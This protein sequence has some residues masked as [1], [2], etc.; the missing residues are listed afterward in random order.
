MVHTIESRIP[1]PLHPLRVGTFL[2]SQL[3]F[4]PIPDKYNRLVELAQTWL[5]ISTGSFLDVYE[6]MK[7]SSGSIPGDVEKTRASWESEHDILLLI[8]G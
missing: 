7:E 8:P 3:L 2:F 1:A 6:S 4:Q 5:I